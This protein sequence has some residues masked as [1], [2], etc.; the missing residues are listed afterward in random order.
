[1]NRLL[2]PLPHRI[3]P[4]KGQFCAFFG[5]LTSLQDYSIIQLFIFI[6][7]NHEKLFF[8]SSLGVKCPIGNQPNYWILNLTKKVIRNIYAFFSKKYW[9]LR[10]EIKYKNIEFYV[11]QSTFS[12]NGIEFLLI[13]FLIVRYSWMSIDFFIRAL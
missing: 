4:Q 12:R 13:S 11:N 6:H 3:S 1:M 8:N 5:I 9:Y 7:Q 2:T 10:I